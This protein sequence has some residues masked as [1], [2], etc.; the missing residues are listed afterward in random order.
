M[1]KHVGGNQPK[2]GPIKV[3]R[4][5]TA[6]GKPAAKGLSGPSGAVQAGGGAQDFSSTLPGVPFKTPPS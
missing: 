3:P 4:K 5:T 6:L 1:T 2:E